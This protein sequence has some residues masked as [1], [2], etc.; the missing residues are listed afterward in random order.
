MPNT[1]SM[2]M[3]IELTNNDVDQEEQRLAKLNSER[4][5]ASEQLTMLKQ[6]REDY[7]S[8]LLET[9]KQ[10]VSMANYHNFYRFIG[11]LDQAITQQGT[12]IEQY[13]EKIELQ[14][15][16]WLDAKQ[17]LNAYEAIQHRRDTER[18]E[19]LARQEQRDNDE[20]S[21]A[22]HYRLHHVKA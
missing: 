5:K 9:S 3:L 2:N 22:M 18:N 8:R 6:Y 11:T 7:T 16:K 12:V 20:L 21:A 14:Q 15:Q 4:A 1:S 10:G 13:A 19:R 17:R